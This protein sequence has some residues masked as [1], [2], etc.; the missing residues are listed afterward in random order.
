MRKV[1][2]DIETST[3]FQDIGSTDPT[4]QEIS[5]VGLWDSATDKFHTFEQE[6]FSD[7]WPIF[8]KADLLIGF[9]SDHF[10]LPLLNKYYLGDLTSI[11]SLD[12]LTELKNALG[13]R[14]RLD[15]V[16]EATLGE[17]KSGHG[18]KA[19]DWWLEG[20]KD[21][22]KKYCLDDV[23]ITKEVYEFALE[24]GGLRY[25]DGGVVTPVKLDTSNWEV[26]EDKAMS[27]SLF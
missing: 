10:D 2:F 27:S 9:N 6:E 7:M 1:V 16:A 13:H 11:K 4:L 22:V 18:L 14:V 17:K 25:I 8:E 24:K 12:L 20:K 5:V 19:V 21:L 23:R 3:S 15:T 26:L